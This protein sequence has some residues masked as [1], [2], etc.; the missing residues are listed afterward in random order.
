MGQRGPQRDPS[1]PNSRARS[2]GNRQT[3]STAFSHAQI[4]HVKAT[5]P[6]KPVGM[7][8]YAATVWDQVVDELFE[9]G[10]ICRL[11]GSMLAEYCEQVAVLKVLRESVQERIKKKESL[12][13]L[14]DQVEKASKIT[15]RLADSFGLTPKGRRAMGINTERQAGGATD[16][17]PGD[18]D[19]VFNG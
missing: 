13:D 18:P 14:L 12:K 6:V 10:L 9:L 5:R 19:L 3:S 11:D 7:T 8:D 1:K 16:A 4:Q 15:G 2:A 17:Q